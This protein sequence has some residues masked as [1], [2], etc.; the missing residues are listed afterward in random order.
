MLVATTSLFKCA[1][2]I[3]QH[4]SNPNLE[5]NALHPLIISDLKPGGNRPHIRFSNL[6]IKNCYRLDVVERG[7]L[8]LALPA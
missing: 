7:D 4:I 8:C 5:Q 1:L 2:I 6:V 3:L